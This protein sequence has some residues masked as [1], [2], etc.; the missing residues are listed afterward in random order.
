MLLLGMPYLI[1]Q[2]PLMMVDVATM[3][4]LTLAVFATIKAVESGKTTLCIFASVAIALAMLTKYSNWLMLSIIP[5]VFLAYYQLGW[6]VIARQGIAIVLGVI[7]LMVMFAARQNT[8]SFWNK[9][10]VVT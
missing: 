7:L 3:F 8:I 10:R 9:L 6:K 1:V 2:V 4:F 5:I